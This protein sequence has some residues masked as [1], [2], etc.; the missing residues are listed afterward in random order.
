MREE[1]LSSNRFFDRSRA[2]NCRGRGK[3]CG[4]WIELKSDMHH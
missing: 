2:V 1:K 3:V 4:N